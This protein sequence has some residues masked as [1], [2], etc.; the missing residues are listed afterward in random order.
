M[1]RLFKQRG[2]RAALGSLFLFLAAHATQPLP[3][4]PIR[5]AE[6]ALAIVVNKA[7]PV[8]NLSFAELR[9]VFLA[10]RNHWPHGRKSVITMRE[11]GQPERV[12]V[13]RQI[14]R[15]SESDYNRHFLQLNYTGDSQVAPKQLATAEKI[16]KFVFN[17]PGAI[18]YVR[19]SEVDDTVKLVQIDGLL[20]RD[21]GYK[22]KSSDR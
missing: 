21:A 18:G 12:A 17:V 4:A 5:A 6:E 20:P 16:L 8:A 1:P 3:A 13:L 11:P 14:Y 10:E 7:N 19:A 15:M 9:Q 2:L 22:L